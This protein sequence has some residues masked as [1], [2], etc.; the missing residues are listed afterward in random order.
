MEK[1]DSDAYTRA[2]NSQ[3]RKKKAHTQ[4]SSCVYRAFATLVAIFTQPTSHL[5]SSKTKWKNNSF[6]LF[7]LSE[8][9]AIFSAC[10]GVGEIW[11]FSPIT[12]IL[13]SFRQFNVFKLFFL[14]GGH[15]VQ[16]AWAESVATLSCVSAILWGHRRTFD[17]CEEI[18][19][20]RTDQGLIKRRCSVS[21]VTV[22]SKG[23]WSMEELS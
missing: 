17:L 22:E 15:L 18:L 13:L 20:Q 19:T 5:L 7:S 3:I 9:T 4:V 2:A 16:W 8:T 14:G 21:V 11:Y 1:E 12:A 6:L 23:E 10:D